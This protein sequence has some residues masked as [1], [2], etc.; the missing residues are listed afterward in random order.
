MTTQRNIAT[1]EAEIQRKKDELV[2][3]K[4][5]E[6]EVYARI[7]GYYRSVRNW[8]K[9]K[10]DEYNHRKQ[11]IYDN[12]GAY[13]PTSADTTCGCSN[14]VPHIKMNEG[15]NHATPTNNAAVKYEFYARK[16]CPNCPPVKEYL[17]NAS[18]PGDL[19]DVDTENGFAQATQKGVFSAPTVI[20]YD[21][22]GTEIA[23]AHTVKELLSVLEPVAVAC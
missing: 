12:N 5:T 3:A 17:S 13:V 7:V 2:N 21:A 18:I 1:I 20:V 14:D 19:V 23:R 4:G 6:T 10:R 16:T 11:F 22:N 8:N 9:G 15:N